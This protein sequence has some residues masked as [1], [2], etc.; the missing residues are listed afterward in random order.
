MTRQRKRALIQLA[1][2]LNW[3]VRKVARLMKH[4]TVY[5]IMRILKK[6]RHVHALMR[7]SLT[8]TPLSAPGFPQSCISLAHADLQG[9]QLALPLS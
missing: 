7:R 8:C 3:E 2:E 5:G 4:Y 6:I 1:N 9:M